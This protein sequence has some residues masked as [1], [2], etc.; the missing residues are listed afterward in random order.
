M[1]DSGLTDYWRRK[2]SPEKRPCES[3]KGQS[4][5]VIGL[6]DTQTAF[7]LAALGAGLGVVA[8]GVERLII[9]VKKTKWTL[10]TRL[11]HTEH[12]CDGNEHL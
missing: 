8:L 6:T 9:G 5:R 7:Y 4:S 11:A 10:N 12:A 2:W 1:V 3:D